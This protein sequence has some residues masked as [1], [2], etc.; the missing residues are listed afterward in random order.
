MVEQVKQYVESICK[1]VPTIATWMGKNIEELSK[2]ELLDIVR[3]LG[4]DVEEERKR[5]QATLEILGLYRKL[6][7]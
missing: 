6:R 5:H 1:S 4:R 7:A 3:K 2:Q